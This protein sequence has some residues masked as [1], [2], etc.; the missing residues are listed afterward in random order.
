MDRAGFSGKSKVPLEYIENELMIEWGLTFEEFNQL[1]VNVVGRI[2]EMRQ[3][4]NSGEIRKQKH[5]KN[6]NKSRPRRK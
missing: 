3:A 4:K 6:I 1:P 2:I 5:N